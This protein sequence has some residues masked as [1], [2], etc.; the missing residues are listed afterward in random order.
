MKMTFW[1]Q[2]RFFKKAFM[3]IL[4]ALTLF[5]L[6]TG[7]IHAV[8]T[9]P[10][11]TTTATDSNQDQTVSVDDVYTKI[12]EM[13][14]KSKTVDEFVQTCMASDLDAAIKLYYCT[15]PLTSSSIY[16]GFLTFGSSDV[17]AEKGLSFYLNFGNSTQTA[18][19]VKWDMW[20]WGTSIGLVILS[21]LGDILEFIGSLFSYV[22]LFVMNI[23]TGNYIAGIIRTACD[24]I[25][26]LLFG[27]ITIALPLLTLVF[28]YHF[29]MV[30]FQDA[31]TLKSAK[32]VTQIF[33]K[34]FLSFLF[35]IL[36]AIPGRQALYYVDN[37]VHE[38]VGSLSSLVFNQDST[39]QSGQSLSTQIKKNV[40][41]L[42]QEQ[43]FMLRHFGEMSI[44]KIAVKYKIT[45][46]EATNRYN[47]LLIFPYTASAK[48]EI[49]AG[50][51]TITR[52]TLSASTNMFVSLVMLIHRLLIGLI[53]S[54]V[55]VFIFALDILKEILIG[56][57][58]LAIFSWMFNRSFSAGRMI[59]N[60]LMW[61]MVVGMVPLLLSVVMMVYSA[62]VEAAASLHFTMVLMLDLGIA[63]L[64]ILAYKNR[65]KIAETITKLKEP[66]SGMMNGTYSL[67]N[68]RDD[69]SGYSKGGSSI[70]SEANEKISSKGNSE[71]SDPHLSEGR[72]DLNDDSHSSSLDSNESLAES[73]TDDLSE[74]P[75]ADDALD[76][77]NDAADTID[78]LEDPQEKTLE[79][80]PE[81]QDSNPD[82]EK[83]ETF[84]SSED[85]PEATT[86]THEENLLEHGEENE[87]SDLSEQEDVPGEIEIDR[88]Q[89]DSEQEVFDQVDDQ[90]ESSDLAESDPELQ[91]NANAQNEEIVPDHES[92]LSDQSS[93]AKPHAITSS[94][95]SGTQKTEQS[96]S[97]PDL[98]EN[99]ESHQLEEATN[100]LFDESDS[101]EDQSLDTGD[102]SASENENEDL[103][104][105]RD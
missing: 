97:M 65:E 4:V 59:A 67:A 104:D 98:F 105:G 39:L 26:K 70:G 5:P 66:I 9:P 47:K 27:N 24:T 86:A 25:Q 51:Q 52:D 31:Q 2:N 30:L 58:L 14:A 21:G 3:F 102:L 53:F 80:K 20:D 36:L 103:F 72:N 45:P 93:Q 96:S 37:K 68:F 11:E 28:L 32:M 22:T 61:I 29:L 10:N 100:D 71:S 18:K 90:S 75:S 7:N 94:N 89:N 6:M 91:N 76:A 46:E 85:L 55:G 15:A 62:A 54:I 79:D 92:N 77:T 40:F 33:I 49:N 43:P 60:R 38:T 56:F 1:T 34:S 83:S 87:T 16:D 63:L 95:A 84:A 8:D 23:A 64:G 44:N 42:M 35:I 57:V 82:D 88:D 101:Q 17:A 81:D 74:K 12:A 69:L 41:Y 99:Q 13:L 19:Y 50:N 73:E 48:N 78:S